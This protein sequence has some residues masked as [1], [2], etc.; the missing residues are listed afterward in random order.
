DERLAGRA[1]PSIGFNFFGAG[2]RGGAE[3]D[4]VVGFMVDPDA[5]ALPATVSGA[6]A[7]MNVLTVNVGTRQ[8][9]HGRELSADLLYVDGILSADDVHGIAERWSAELAAIVDAVAH[10]DIGP[11]PSDVAGTGVTQADLDRITDLHPG[12][13]IWP[14]S[15]LQKGLYLQSALAADAVDVYVSQ[16]VLRLG[17][18]VDEGRLRSAVQ[19]LVAHHRVLRSSYLRTDGGAVVAVIPEHVE[20]PWRTVDLGAVDDTERRRRVD[21]ETARERVE[22]FDLAHPPLLRVVLVRDDSGVSVV[23]TNHHILF[24]GW[25]GPLVLADLLALYASGA[26]YTG[27]IA[28]GD[29]DFADHLHRL[30]AADDD[31]GLAAWREVLAPVEGATLVAPGV[32]ATRESLPRNHAVVVDAELTAA[33]DRLARSQGATMATVLQFAWALLVSRLTGNR[34]VTFGETVSGRPA[35][36]EGVEAMVG[37]FI[38]TLPAVVDVDPAATVA[39][40]LQE[41]QGTKISVLDHQHLGLP[42]LTALT[43]VGRLFDTL[44]VHESYPVDTD[45]LSTTDATA[46]GGL[47]ILEAQVSDSTHYPLN[48]ITAPMGEQLSITLKYLPDA[49]SDAQVAV[50][51]DAIVQILRAAATAPATQIADVELLTA[52]TGAAMVDRSVGAEVTVPD[53]T[54]ADAV[55]AQIA[56]T[57]DDV[58]LVFDD[59]SVTYAEL[60]ARTAVLARELIAIGVA[61]G[62]AVGVSMDRSVEL[63][64]AIHAVVA[65]G[66]QYVPIDPGMPADRVQYM[67]E[68]AGVGIVLAGPAGAPA[69][70]AGLGAAITVVEVDTSGAV[71]VSVAPVTDADRRAPVRLDDAL[72]TLFTSGS[73]GRPKGVTVSHRAVGNRL[74]WGLDEYPWTTGDRVV[75]KTP[76]TFD[77]SV[78][79]LFAPLMA[80]ATVIIASAGGHADPMHIAELIA[81][82]RATSVHFVPSMLSV[83]L[84]VVPA[85]KVSALSSLR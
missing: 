83:F 47:D 57:P 70:V 60:G 7:A 2:G 53:G 80:G 35:D 58:A 40:V 24:D 46:S 26:T 56:R 22:P 29:R 9:T 3:Q 67:I 34:V 43:G 13:A 17:G 65:A 82:Q 77:V 36:L 49:F 6:M 8:R 63:V 12:A 71:D 16:A 33:L 45:S 68:T 41:L 54:V 84:D 66:G 27:Q 4:L 51:A 79:E 21:D 72:Y 11:S 52:G 23:I 55:C 20:V 14:L 31:A 85:E 73:T 75:L 18:E 39:E 69:S 81:K 78:P 19:G 15:P 48:M 5:P 37:L 44:T 64:V 42:E 38:N 1:L 10:G 32:E 61:P 30:A 50:F 59:R 62:V 25:S 28:G 76:F 74:W